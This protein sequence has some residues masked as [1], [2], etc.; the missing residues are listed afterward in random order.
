MAT[1]PKQAILA[2]GAKGGK[3]AADA[4]SQALSSIADE[5]QQ[6]L[7]AA[8]ARSGALNAPQAFIDSQ[9]KIAAL[10]GDA[11]SRLL[12]SIQGANAQYG[13]A[14]AGAQGNFNSS[15]ARSKAL[16][17]QQAAAQAADPMQFLNAQLK[18][19][20][21]YD[22]L[23]QAANGGVS[24][25]EKRA[26]QQFEWAK[27][28]R[29]Q[30]LKDQYDQAQ[31]DKLTADYA[32]SSDP[33]AKKALKV[34]SGTKTY[35]EALAALSDDKNPFSKEFTKLNEDEQ[36]KFMEYLHN[37]YDPSGAYQQESQSLGIPG[38]TGGQYSN[39]W[40]VQ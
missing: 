15:I 5:R 31:Q 12:Q 23:I 28:D 36:T 37:I 3:T 32:R 4:Y 10:P 26:E 16:L 20:T 9:A 14:L 29:E 8:A 35:A 30:K 2:A 7:Q 38:Q 18:A 21:L 24:P 11:N 13:G 6:A 27:T 1:N 19:K 34:F 22:K 39:P 40:T 17:S 25:S 33:L